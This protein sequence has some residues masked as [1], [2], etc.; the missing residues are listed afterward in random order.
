[1]IEGIIYKYTSPN[2]K[3]YIGQ[4]TNEQRRKSTFLREHESYG[5][6]RIDNAR[7][8]Y[9]ANNFTYEILHKKMYDDKSIMIKDLNE[10]ER[11]YIGLYNSYNDGYNMT[12]GGEGVRGLE[13]SEDS[14]KGYKEYIKNKYK[15]YNDIT[16]Y[17]VRKKGKKRVIIEKD[18][19]RCGEKNSF[20]GKK[21]TEKT[22]EIIGSKNGKSV[23][24]ID[25]DTNEIINIFESAKQAADT[26]N[27][28]RGNSEIIKV[29]RGS[30]K[31]QDGYVK[32]Y[33]TAYGYKWRYLTDIKGSTTTETDGKTYYRP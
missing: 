27:T 30:S 15:D 26:F 4:T 14:K 7:K 16:P 20:Y 25:K 17:P 31:L 22:K 5:G 12:T 23:V 9:G 8:K 19:N 13:R 33:R 6:H 18:I 32:H 3:V 28:P 29:C 2:G 1:M 10:K 24:Q 21:H 11:Y